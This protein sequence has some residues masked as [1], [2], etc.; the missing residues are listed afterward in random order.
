MV[1]TIRYPNH[2]HGCDFLCF[3]FM[4][5][6]MSLRIF[7]RVVGANIRCPFFRGVHLIKGA[8]K[9]ELHCTGK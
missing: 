4:N 7:L 1:I 3:L 5:Y 2:H 8:I 9:G 6:L